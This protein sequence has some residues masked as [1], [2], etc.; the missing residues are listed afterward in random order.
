[1]VIYSSVPDCGTPYPMSFSP[2]NLIKGENKLTFRSDD[3]RY[4][5]NQI[6]ITTDLKDQP[7]YTYFFS[8]DSNDLKDILKSFM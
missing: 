6:K 4:L 7:S 2:F 5:I 1:M 3:G 8:L